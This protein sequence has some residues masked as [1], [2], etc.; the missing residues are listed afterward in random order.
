MTGTPV[1]PIDR[2]ALA[3]WMAAHGSAPVGPLSLKRMGFGQSNLT[4]EVRDDAGSRWVARRPPL[5]VHLASAHDV[6]REARIMSALGATVVPTPAVIGLCTD[7][8]V[9]RGAPVVIMEMV[10]GVVL[11]EPAKVA[12]IPEATRHAVGTSVAE[13][14]A[15]VHDV[16]LQEVGLN[17]LASHGPY[18]RRQIKRW[19]RQWED[20]KLRP[21]PLVDTLTGWLSEHAPDQ[22]ETRLLHGDFHLSNLLLDGDTGRVRAVLDWELSTLGE[23]L[24][25][26]GT[27]LAYWPQPGDPP[28][29]E[30][31]VT[32]LPG[33][34]DRRVMAETYAAASGRAIED[35]GYWYVLG[36]WKIAIIVAGI[37]RRVHDEP[38]NA[39]EGGPP[40]DEVVVRFAEQAWNAVESDVLSG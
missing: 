11:D 6:A 20:S 40:S 9:G 19:S 8:E 7:P 3:R 17:D 39:A 30:R 22:T 32:V 2:A 25:D 21:L 16:N 15:A 29:Q 10:D 23:P 12:P 14:L 38:A 31:A 4:Y 37:Q 1:E 28:L 27:M 35:V 24:A 26:V 33:F 34:P 18:A 13:T 36:L 5:G